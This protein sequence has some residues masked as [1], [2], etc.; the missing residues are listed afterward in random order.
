MNWLGILSG[1]TTGLGAGLVRGALRAAEPIYSGIMR[2]R[3]K[4]YDT[5]FLSQHA[6]GRPTISVGNLTTGGTGKTPMVHWI[7][8]Q[9]R[10]RGHRPAVLMRGYGRADDPQS[11]D[12]AALLRQLLGKQTIVQA[13]PD[14]LAGAAAA[15][16]QEPAIDCFILDDAF[17]HRRVARDFNLLLVSATNPFGYG[18]VL[19]RGLLREPMGG[20]A[21]ADA[22]VITHADQVTGE[23]LEQIQSRLP[24]KAI[25]FARHVLEDLG[26]LKGRKYAIFSA[27][28]DPAAFERQVQAQIGEP[29]AARRFA[30]HHAY[31]R[32]D[33]EAL[34]QMAES[35]GA[36]V[37]LTT[38]KDGVKLAAFADAWRVP[39]RC[40]GVRMD[41]GAGAEPLL[42]L[43]LSVLPDIAPL[44]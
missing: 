26:E 19:P 40:V 15:L 41:V 31:T 43:L 36:E 24:N 30:D 9:L 14:R 44:R 17:Q 33:A 38:Q 2:L 18:H 34:A 8:Q 20:A 13:N 39:P 3:N 16:E 32:A 7:V 27:I 28:G 10:D 22:I 4:L 23:V 29:V 5:G 12:E 1:E 35:Q 11:A 42:D 21:R 25:F 6:L 37:L